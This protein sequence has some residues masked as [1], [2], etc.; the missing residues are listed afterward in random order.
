MIIKILFIRYKQIY[1][2]IKDVGIIGFLVMFAFLVFLAFSTFQYVGNQDY[3]KI[4]VVSAYFL[5]VTALHFNR[6]DIKFLKINILSFKSIIFVEYLILSI[7]LLVSLLYYH[8]FLFFIS[9]IF[10][11]YILSNTPNVRISVFNFNVLLRFVPHKC[12]EWKAGI[13]KNFIILSILWALGLIL[14]FTYWFSPI[15]IFFIGLIV[16]EFYNKNEPIQMLVAQEMDAKTFLIKK[17]VKALLLFSYLVL[18]LIFAYILFNI[19]LWYIPILEYIVFISAIIFA[20][21]VKYYF[22]VPNKNAYSKQIY[23]SMAFLVSLF[24]VSLPVV[25]ILSIIIY[26][27]AVNNLEIYLYDYN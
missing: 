16:I 4:F 6:A 11:V 21:F 23:V 7:P 5:I 2:E 17:I 19:S 12:F 24:V 18:P 26:K 8:K 9:Y 20:I 25:W 13:R 10:I 14:S 22:Y 3:N 15:S 27:K 1:R